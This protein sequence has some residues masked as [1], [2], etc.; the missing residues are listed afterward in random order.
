MSPGQRLVYLLL[1]LNTFQ[2]IFQYYLCRFEQLN[3][4]WV[5]AKCKKKPHATTKV[6]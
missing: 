6:K 3:V 4:S 1:T 5:L 2:T